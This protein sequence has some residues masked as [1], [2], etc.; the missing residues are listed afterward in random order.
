MPEHQRETFRSDS[1]DGGV[2]DDDLVGV[3]WLV[4]LGVS[5]AVACGM[6]AQ[7]PRHCVDE[8]VKL[9]TLAGLA[10]QLELAIEDRPEL[11][12]G[13]LLCRDPSEV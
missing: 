8:G 10:T 1:A 3:R 6:L 5:L 9:R 7:S 11:R 13:D 12:F 2:V 4:P